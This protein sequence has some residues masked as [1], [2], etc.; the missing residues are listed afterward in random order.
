MIPCEM[1]NDK[2]KKAK[3]RINNFYAGSVQQQAT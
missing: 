1:H 3:R 2:K